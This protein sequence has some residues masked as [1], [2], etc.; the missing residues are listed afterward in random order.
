MTDFRSDLNRRFWDYAESKFGNAHE[1]FDRWGPDVKRPPVFSK[2]D[3]WRNVIFDPNATEEER[4]R[5]LDLVPEDGRHRWFGSMNSSQ[6]LAQSV[7]GNLIV[8]GY[9]GMLLDLEDDEGMSLIE[10]AA[11]VPTNLKLEY[12][13][14]NLGEPR[15]TSIDAF[16]D[17]DYRVAI[18]CKF[19]EQEVGAC[20][21]PR[22][23][24]S[25]SNYGRDF[26]DGR[27]RV[28]CGRKHRCSLAE[29]GVLYWEFIPQLFDWTDDKD[30]DPCP[31]LNNYQ[32]VRNVLAV[33]VLPTGEV[34]S[35]N[36]HALLICDN[37][38]D[39]FTGE[40]R[41]TRAFVE[42]REALKQKSMLRKTSWQ[43]IAGHMRE[44]GILPW[45]TDELK[46]KYDL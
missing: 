36:G 42:T 3:A 37:R 31:L 46:L 18:E 43:C 29:R 26:C 28:Q 12:E 23:P 40:G 35:K 14:A 44:Q 34:S 4:Q 9:L 16:I 2:N 25:A 41:G 13:V 38:N 30:H 17:G 32:L 1:Y 45:L 24:E 10:D 5:L 33:G 27:Y 21:R 19:T 8:H 6:A 15:P 22:I 39:A 11:I 20:S 7:L